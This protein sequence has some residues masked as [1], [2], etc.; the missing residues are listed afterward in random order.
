MATPLTDSKCFKSSIQG[1][2]DLDN[3]D[4]QLILAKYC[5]EIEERLNNTI[6]EL[7]NIAD[8]KPSG[9][10]DMA[11]QFRP[12]AQNRA[13]AAAIKATEEFNNE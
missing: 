13:R 7:N 8:A 5:R 2:G 3:C 6:A 9:W 10:G 12:W 4:P 11:D 1:H